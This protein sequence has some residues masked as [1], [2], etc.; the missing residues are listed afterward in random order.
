MCTFHVHLQIH[1]RSRANSNFTCFSILRLYVYRLRA[2]II[3]IPFF[4]IKLTPLVFLVTSELHIMLVFLFIFPLFY[5]SM[6]LILKRC[7]TI[8]VC[9]Y[10][11]SGNISLRRVNK[12]SRGCVL[13]SGKLQKYELLM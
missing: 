7:I 13:F 11:I 6:L 12:N 9:I 8:A 2:F 3:I 5:H 1:C 4:T 10:C